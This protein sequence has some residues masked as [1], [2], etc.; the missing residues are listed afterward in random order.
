[1]IL[2]Q[3]Y[4]AVL[5][6]MVFSLLC[7]GSWANTFKLAAKYR[8]EMYYVDFAV[9]CMVLALICAFTLGNLGFDGF[10]FLD[11]LEHAG[12][13][14]W[15]YAFVAGGIF[16]LANMLLVAAI[17]VSG[18]AVAFPAGIGVAIIMGSL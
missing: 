6:L 1:M 8:F 11:D 18:L 12:K 14:Q 4:T 5:M 17:S 3:T 7:W 13:R 9:G 2:P 15:L 16:N 10:S